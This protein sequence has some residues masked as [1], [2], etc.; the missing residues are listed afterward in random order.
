MNPRSRRPEPVLKRL[1]KRAF[2]WGCLY[3]G[4]VW[5]R[6]GW[7]RLWRRTRCT[8]LLYHRVNN[9]SSDNLT[10]SEQRFIEHMRVL[11][12]RYPVLGLSEAV[13]ALRAGHYLGPNLVVITFDDGY[14]DN[15]DIAAPIL[16]H[17]GLPAT[18]FVTAGLMGTTRRF[19]HDADSPHR[20]ANLTWEQIRSLAARGF[21]IGS[22]GMS[23]R[24]LARCP[25][26]DARSEIV[27]SRELLGEKLGTPPRS[28]AF[29]FGGS[30]D[31]TAG[32]LDDIT[33]AGF[34]VVASAYGGVNAGHVDPRNVLRI[35]VSEAFDPLAFRAQ[36]EGVALRS[37][38][39][40]V[41][42]LW[43]RPERPIR[44]GAG[45]ASAAGRT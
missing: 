43:A 21:E 14:A 9:V 36:I 19:D 22:H 29:P 15:H 6:N 12:R 32:L 25:R 31:I 11:R 41:L 45:A 28:F 37:L 42:A 39:S 40:R 27:R 24:N 33:A 10:T 18:F 4:P 2:Y 8:V 44:R 26:E 16:Q 1:V 34:D 5:L 3:G 38:R 17:F 30:D 35:S 7:L 13:A 20:F 23:H